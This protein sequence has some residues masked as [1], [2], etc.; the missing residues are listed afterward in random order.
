MTITCPKCR[1]QRQATDS[2]PDWQC[3][4]CGVA[5]AKVGAAP[6]PTPAA[7]PQSAHTA[8]TASAELPE[9]L[10]VYNDEQARHVR[11]QERRISPRKFAVLFM[12]GF[13][14]IASLTLVYY[15]QKWR[16]EREAEFGQTQAVAPAGEGRQGNFVTTAEELKQDRQLA[17]E[18]RAL[19]DRGQTAKAR[20]LLEA[21]AGGK[22]GYF[23]ESRL[24]LAH[25]Y[26]DGEGVPVNRER[27]LEILTAAAGRGS[28]AAA[29]EIGFI[30]EFATDLP[31]HMQRALSWY[32]QTAQRGSCFGQYSIGVIYASADSSPELRDSGFAYANKSTAYAYLKMAA[33]GYEENARVNRSELHCR[34]EVSLNLG[35]GSGSTPATIHRVRSA[36]YARADL[37]SLTSALPAD[38]VRKGEEMF[39]YWHSARKTPLQIRRAE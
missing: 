4:S 33:A 2:A 8:S 11:R 10:M 17:A 12:G 38:E 28:T 23:N 37:D 3:P 16:A 21:R 20:T 19:L 36:A 39:D 7:R 29:N 25:M 27:A 5:Y 26:L 22:D 18:A 32:D 1:Y 9:G 24:V 34:D 6:A 30:Y 14:L 35:E 13:A 15:K 31:R